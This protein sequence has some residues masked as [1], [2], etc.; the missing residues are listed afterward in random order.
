MK[1]TRTQPCS[2]WGDGIALFEWHTKARTLTPGVVEM[3]RRAIHRL[4]SDFDGLVVGHDGD[5]FSGGA[6]LDMMALQQQAA[7]R[8][9]TPA[10]VVEGL[11]NDMQQMMLSFRYAPK[12]VVTAPFDR[13]LGGGGE[14]TM[15]GDRIVAHG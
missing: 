3:S 2:I 6:N 8:G 5:L 10:E 13:A 9:I 1:R 11:V 4:E 12:P 14:L 7:Q 15:A